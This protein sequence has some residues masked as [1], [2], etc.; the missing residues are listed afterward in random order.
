MDEFESLSH[1]RWECKYHTVFIPKGRR[2]A[3]FGQHRPYLGEVLRRLAARKESRIAESRLLPDHVD[4]M[5]SMPR[6][7][8]VSQVIGCIKGKSAIH[9][10][11]VYGERKRNFTATN[12]LWIYPTRCR[13]RGGAGAVR[14]DV[15]RLV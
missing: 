14:F 9:L 6:K 1:S 12:L 5:I 3:L 13:R 11:R 10:A 7:Y 4:M 8:A 15:R 2:K